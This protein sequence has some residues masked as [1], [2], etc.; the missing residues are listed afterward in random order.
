[1]VSAVLKFLSFI[2]VAV[3]GGVVAVWLTANGEVSDKPA[4]QAML[5]GYALPSDIVGEVTQMPAAERFRLGGYVEARDTV[6]LTAQAPGR[7]VFVAGQE[8]ERVSAGQV[9]VALDDDAIQPQY[10]EAWAALAGEMASQQNAQTQLFHKFNGDQVSPLGGPGYEAYDQMAVPL[11]NMAQSFMR[12]M[13]PGM[14][15]GPYSP[16]AGIQ[17]LVTQRQSQRGYPAINNAR[18]EYENRLAGL[19]AAQARIDKI[20][21]QLRARWSVSPRGGAIMKRHVRLGDVVQPGQPLI[22]LADVDQLD[23]RIEVPISQAANLKVGDQVPVTITDNNLWAP[24]S[25]IFPAANGAQRTVT[26][27]L[28]LPTTARAA[29]GM[30]ALA[31]IAQ[32]GGG[33]PSALA[34]AVPTQAITRRGSLPVVFTVDKQGNAEMRVLRLGDTQGGRTAVLSGV[35]AGERIVLN[36]SPNLKSGDS[37]IGSPR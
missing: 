30:Y 37:L 29:P 22:D 8:G 13:F 20:D 15:G 3:V 23:V 31:W 32:P 35:T 4:P 28:A 33:S 27:K 18:A 6:R 10:R 26:V 17:P 34:P 1:M 14:T 11:Y 25:Q 16:L 7:V 21:A 2:V 24:V 5:G 36:P 12:Q 19:V 9:I